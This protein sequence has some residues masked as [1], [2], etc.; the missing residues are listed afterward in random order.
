MTAVALTGCQS[1]I[2]FPRSPVRTVAAPPP[3]GITS[4]VW[5]AD[6]ARANRI[7]L[8]SGDQ[9]GWN[10]AA[11]SVVS[12]WSARD[13]T[14]IVQTSNEPERLLANAIRDP[15]G[16]QAGCTFRAAPLV[17]TVIVPPPDGTTQIW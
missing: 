2:S 15:S 8:P 17:S 1:G 7:R 6:V 5:P 9:A 10:S 13:P 4:M 11:E 12:R 14:V 3:A 16:D